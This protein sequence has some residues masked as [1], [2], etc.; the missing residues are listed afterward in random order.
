MTIYGTTAKIIG[1]Y[2][3]YSKYFTETK[4]IIVAKSDLDKDKYLTITLEYFNT[5]ADFGRYGTLFTSIVDMEIN[6]ED[7]DELTKNITL[8]PIN[9]HYID[10]NSI[11]KYCNEEIHEIK[12]EIFE[13]SRYGNK[14]EYIIDNFRCPRGEV[15]FNE[16]LFIDYDNKKNK[17]MKLEDI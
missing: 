1:M 9:E 3:L 7:R 11:V 4:Y 10:L 13:V 2:K 17:K 6:E 16:D 12:C 15:Y 14:E 5:Y 8:F